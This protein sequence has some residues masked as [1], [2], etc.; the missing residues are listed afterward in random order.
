MILFNV[1]SRA[2]S[3]NP[4][5]PKSWQ[6]KYL[7]TYETLRKKVFKLLSLHKE[8]SN[9]NFSWFLLSYTP[10]RIRYLSFWQREEKEGDWIVK[11]LAWNSY[12][13]SVSIENQLIEP[14]QVLLKLWLKKEK[15]T[16]WRKKKKTDVLYLFKTSI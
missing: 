13:L 11:A 16:D 3:R 6:Q 2:R 4:I 8:F 5:L 12:L 7:H 9:R 14:L 10:N 1:H 15:K